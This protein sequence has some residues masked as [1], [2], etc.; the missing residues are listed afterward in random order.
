MIPTHV[1]AALTAGLCVAVLSRGGELSFPL[2]PAADG[3]ETIRAFAASR[4]SEVLAML[5]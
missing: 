5:T 2:H 3:A 4:E 1:L